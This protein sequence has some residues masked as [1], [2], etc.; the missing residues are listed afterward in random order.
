[1]SDLTGRLARARVLIVGLCVVGGLCLGWAVGSCRGDEK[2][3]QE[4]V[5]TEEGAARC[6]IVAVGSQGRRPAEELALYLERISGAKVR[7]RGELVAKGLRK[8]N[9]T[10]MRVNSLI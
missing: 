9:F 6:A 5:L 10:I 3:A 1:M 2:K 8:N 7:V 4:V